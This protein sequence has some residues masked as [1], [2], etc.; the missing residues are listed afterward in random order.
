MRLRS[1]LELK[2][3]ALGPA[4]DLLD[5]IKRLERAQRRGTPDPLPLER[6]PT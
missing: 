2:Y 4:L 6:G 5:R 1:Y 3:N